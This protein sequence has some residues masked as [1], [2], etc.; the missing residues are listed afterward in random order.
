MGPPLTKIAEQKTREYLLESMV[1]PN[2]TIAE[3]WG[4]TA[5]QLQSDEVEV[6]RVAKE[7]TDWLMLVLPDGKQK[8]VPKA[9]IKA[10]KAA[11]SAMPEDIVKQLSK[12]DL[13]DLV[14]FLAG[15]K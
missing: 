12:R 14:A 4:Q 15:L 3:G 10:R 11:L 7:T 1:T 2:K 6:G 9:Q 8:A 13:R 5:V